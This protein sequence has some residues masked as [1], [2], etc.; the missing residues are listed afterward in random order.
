MRIHPIMRAALAPF[1]PHGRSFRTATIR[2]DIEPPSGLHRGQMV[3][4]RWCAQD[5]RGRDIYAVSTTNQFNGYTR[6]FCARVLENFS[7]QE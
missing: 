5:G 3:Y 2:T 4:V 6:T 1:V 7:I